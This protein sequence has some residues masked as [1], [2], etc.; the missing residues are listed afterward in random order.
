MGPVPALLRSLWDEPRPPAAPPRVW[1]DWVLVGAL[2]PAAVLEGVLRP[3]LPWRVLSVAVTVGLVPTLLWRRTRPLAMVA[4]AYGACG[5]ALLVTRGQ[6]AMDTSAYLLL[7]PYCLYRWGSGREAVTGSG[8]VL[9]N[10]VLSVAVGNIG[11]TDAVAAVV[12][13]F[14]F[15][16]LGS[17]VR[18]RARARQR[19]VDQVKPLE[20][21][22]L[23]RDLHDTVAHHVSAMAIR[24]Q[25]GLATAQSN[26]D[27]A[28]EAL[29]PRPGGD[30]GHGARAAARRTRRPRA[31]AARRR[32]RRARQRR[33]RRERHAVRSGRGGGV[34]RRR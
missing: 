6:F 30:A 34:A 16:A 13:L 20:R 7:L 26:P 24:A 10:V 8:I 14:A 28:A 9:A 23:A 1:R 5:L 2:V 18:Y 32:P 33:E 25:A 22:R 17:A 31:R 29:V 15:I 27:A 11:R 12:V 19:E 4:V 3:D 21:E